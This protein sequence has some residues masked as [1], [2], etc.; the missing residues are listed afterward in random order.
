MRVAES[1]KQGNVNKY[2]SIS[3]FLPSSLSPPCFEAGE[4]HALCSS[5][6]TIFNHKKK[7]NIKSEG[8]HGIV[9]A[10]RDITETQKSHLCVLSMKSERTQ[11]NSRAAVHKHSFA[12][13][14][15]SKLHGL[16]PRAN[17]TDR[18][19]AVIRPQRYCNF[20]SDA[21]TAWMPHE[22]K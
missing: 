15:N 9:Q 3:L 1:T 7:N 2:K 17:Y 4:A 8:I 11:S 12:R 21:A 18:A 20:P 10:Y 22:V 13:K 14:L 16:S 6:I 19:T 5:V